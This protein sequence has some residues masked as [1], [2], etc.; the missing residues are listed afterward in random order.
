MS[1][2]GKEQRRMD[3]FIVIPFSSTCRNGSSVDVVDGGK[4]GKKPQGSRRRRRRRGRRRRGGEQAQ[5]GVA[6]GEASPGVQEPVPDLRRVRGRRRGGGGGGAGD[7]DRPPHRRKAR[8]A[9]RLGRQHQHHH[10]PPLLEP[11]R[12][13]VLLRLRRVHLVGLAGAAAAAVPAAAAAA[14]VLHAAVRARHGGAGRRH[15]DHHGE[16]AWLTGRCLFHRPRVSPC[17]C[18]CAWGRGRFFLSFL[19]LFS[20][21]FPCAV[22]RSQ[23]FPGD[24]FCSFSPVAFCQFAIAFSSSSSSRSRPSR[25]LRWPAA[26]ACEFYGIFCPVSL[27]AT[28]SR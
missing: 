25:W 14:G 20:R 22:V 11:R 3:R 6:G 5:G 27:Y 21:L 9:H 28:R 15:G 16:L 26:R 12:A 10:Q 18:N 7:G 1:S 4:S 13:A 23:H 24:P 8:G 17:V 19:R 2:S